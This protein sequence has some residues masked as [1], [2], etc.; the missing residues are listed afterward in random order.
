MRA[1]VSS[2]VAGSIVSETR[3][4]VSI[5]VE[6]INVIAQSDKARAAVSVVLGAASTEY[7]IPLSAIDYIQIDVTSAL[8]EEG[9]YKLYKDSAV[10][11]DQ[12]AINFAKQLVDQ[13]LASDSPALHLQKALSE[14]VSTSDVILITIIL[15]RSFSDSSGATDSQS[16]AISKALEDLPLAADALTLD[17]AKT[18]LDTFAASDAPSKALA[19]PLQD[20]S[21]VADETAL[22]SQKEVGDSANADDVDLRSVAKAL[23]ETSSA[24]D[25]AAIQFDGALADS[26]TTA[27]SLSRVVSWDRAPVDSQLVV[28]ALAYAFTTEFA[29]EAYSNDAPANSVQKPI[30][31]SI[32]TS[33]VLTYEIVAAETQLLNTYVLNFFA[34]N[35]P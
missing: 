25:Q 33:D 26:T 7:Q 5:S 4:D 34:L 15:L 14:S 11:L 28:D 20:S 31:D 1:A 35:G 29:D 8:D 2:V 22:A 23:V 17:Y 6:A 12:T 3:P 16:F 32:A 30:E 24:Q 21:S 9:W 19:K 10:V 27:D 18:L 13:A